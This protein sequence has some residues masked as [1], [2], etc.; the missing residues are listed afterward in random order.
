MINIFVRRLT[1]GFIFTLPLLSGCSTLLSKQPIHTTYYSLDSVE[2]KTHADNISNTNNTLPTLIINPPKAAAG[3]DTRH[4]MYTRMPH[5]LEYFARNEWID[6]P[7]HLLQPLIVSAIHYKQ[8]FITVI[9]KPNAIKA[10]L[11]LESEMLRLLQQFDSKPS[12]VRF[13]LRV[14]IINNATGKIVALRE[15]DERVIATSDDPTG[16]VIAANQAVKL[17]LD[18]LVILSEEAVMNWKQSEN[19]PATKQSN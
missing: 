9:S 10:D 5:Q 6:T 2:S 18:K 13:T 1:Q 15:F 16:G 7:A 4:M 8:N 3:F 12:V 14:S 11:R 19:M 17:A